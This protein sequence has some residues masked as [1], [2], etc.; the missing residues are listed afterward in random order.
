MNDL[1]NTLNPSKLT[2]SAQSAITESMANILTPL[3]W[4]SV[5]FMVLWLVSKIFSAYRAQKLYKTVLETKKDIE[6]IKQ[7]LQIEPTSVDTVSH[8][9]NPLER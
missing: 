7:R 1:I 9:N 5:A 3:I 4:L 8:A 2:D 6:I